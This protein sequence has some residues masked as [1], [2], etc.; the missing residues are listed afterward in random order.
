MQDLKSDYTEVWIPTVVAPLVPFADRVRS[1][2]DTGIDTL[3]IPCRAPSARLVEELRG[4]DSI[5]SWYGT[6]REEF[7]EALRAIG[8]QAEFRPPLPPADSPLHAVDFFLG[9]ESTRYPSI[10][11]VVEASGRPYVA[12]HPF[13]GST[14][15]NWPLSKFREIEPHLPAPAIYCAGP[16]Q[17][18]PGTVQYARLDRLAGWIRGAALYIGNDSGITHLAA[19]TGVPTVAIFGYSNPRIWSPRGPNVRVVHANSIQDV[20]IDAVLDAVRSLLCG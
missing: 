12:I 1:I 2:A 4:F 3:G 6:N 20:T 17:I 15:K 18:L 19:A 8:V 5:V 16:E 9:V 13:S 7:G 14:H 11:P 10:Q